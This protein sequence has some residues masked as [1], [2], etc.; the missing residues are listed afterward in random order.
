M[1]NTLKQITDDFNLRLKNIMAGDEIDY[2][3]IELGNPSDMLKGCGLPDLPI[4]M[5]VLRLVDKKMQTN[6]PFSLLS[7]FS[8][9]EHLVAPI[10]VFNSKT[11]PGRKVI[12]TDI[13][14]Y[15]KDTDTHANMLVVIEPFKLKGKGQ[16]NDVR[17]IYPKDN[18]KDI[19]RWIC[20]GLI[21]DCCKQKVLNWLSKQQSNSAEVAQLIKDST[22][23][24]SS[25]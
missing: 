25:M 8:L 11:M 3:P 4:Q 18:S 23:I 2:T 13:V 9:P 17:S 1:D 24:V 10:A 12:L 5:T 20:D 15:N 22:N 19:M 6:H 7:V 14:N 21:Q 16:V